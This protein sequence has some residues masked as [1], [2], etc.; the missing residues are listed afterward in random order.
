MIR[1]NRRSLR[2]AKADPYFSNNS[3]LLS[4]DGPHGSTQ[5]L[6]GSPIPKVVTPYGDAKIS[7]QQSKF[8]GAS[9]YFDGNMDYL[10]IGTSFTSV[11]NAQDFTLEGWFRLDGAQPDV[12][13][14]ILSARNNT[15]NDSFMFTVREDGA[16]FIGW[17]TGSVF[18]SFCAVTGLPSFAGIWRHIAWVRQGDLHRIFIDGSNVVENVSSGRPINSGIANYVGYSGINLT[19]YRYNYLGYIDDLRLTKGI[20]RYIGNF[21]PPTEPFQWE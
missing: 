15:A 17:K 20:A 21:V 11:F 1:R 3:L 10:Q 14:A 2:H 13:G 6:D 5:Y 16:S 12:V 4:M 7:T 8:G 18:E 19:G 9:S